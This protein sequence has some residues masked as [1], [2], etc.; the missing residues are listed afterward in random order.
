M[1]KY[2]L[3]YTEIIGDNERISE[4]ILETDNI[5]WSIDQFSRNRSIIKMDIKSVK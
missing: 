1:K 3:I 2:K 5:N 4:Q